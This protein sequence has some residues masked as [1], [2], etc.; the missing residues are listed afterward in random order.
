MA[1]PSL[2]CL[3]APQ[4]ASAS[5]FILRIAQPTSIL[6]KLCVTNNAGEQQTA[7]E[8][9]ASTH[10]TPKALYAKIQSTRL[11]FLRKLWDSA[12]PCVAFTA[13]RVR[14]SSEMLTPSFY[15]SPSA[16]KVASTCL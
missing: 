2:A 8:S 15:S 14:L 12:C 4:S 5:D 6:S 9:D 16:L 7:C 3:Y 10:R 1:G 11:L 13:R